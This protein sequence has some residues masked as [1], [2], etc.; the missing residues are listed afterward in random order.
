M[1]TFESFV[2]KD[3]S[4]IADNIDSVLYSFDMVYHARGPLLSDRCQHKTFQEILYGHQ[5]L[6]LR[7]LVLFS[8]SLCSLSSSISL[9]INQRLYFGPNLPSYVNIVG[10]QLF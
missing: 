9:S 3:R 10:F 8:D 2:H 6:F 1:L 5:K 7:S 4:T